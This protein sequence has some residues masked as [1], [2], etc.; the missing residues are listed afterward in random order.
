MKVS[1][2]IQLISLIG[3]SKIPIDIHKHL[4]EEHYSKSKDTFIKIGD[5]DLYH[6]IRSHL[7]DTKNIWNDMS[8]KSDK[9]AKIQR[10]LE[11]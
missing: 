2:V 1:K 9:L 4:N 3:D 8:D 10:I 11:D 7:K 6:Y 5:M